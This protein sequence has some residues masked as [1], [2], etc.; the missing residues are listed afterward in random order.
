MTDDKRL[1]KRRRTTAVS[2]V[3]GLAVAGAEAYG[4]NIYS[5]I[6]SLV[7]FAVIATWQYFA[8]GDFADTMLQLDERQKHVVSKAR[9]LTGVVMTWILVGWAMFDF[10]HGI[11]TGPVIT[12][13]ALS[14]AVFLGSVALIH[15]RS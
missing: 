3:L 5:A 13:C 4:G 7:L 2:I 10:A 6:F 1:I 11:F 14:G 15:Y 8:K 9:E 12:L